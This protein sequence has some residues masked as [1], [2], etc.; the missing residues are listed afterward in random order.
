MFNFLQNKKY[1]EENRKTVKEALTALV[2]IAFASIA[3]VNG[4]VFQSIFIVQGVITRYY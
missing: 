1:S 4:G 3:E 2:N